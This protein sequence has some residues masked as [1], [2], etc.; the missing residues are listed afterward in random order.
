MKTVKTLR[1]G[2]LLLILTSFS[3]DKL[4]KTFT[5]LLDR[6][7]LTFQKPTG[8]EETQIIKNLEMNYEYAIK[9]PQRKFEVRYAI[10]P[11]DNLIRDY[12]EKE[13]KKNRGE[14]NIHPNKLYSSL[15]QVT[16]LN[17]SGGQLPELTVFDK[18]A[19]K[20]EFNADW[21]ATTFVEVGKEFGQEYKYCMIVAIH[22]DNC[23]DA[24]FF[25]LS[26]TKDGYDELMDP[27][28]HSLKFK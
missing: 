3:S 11:L 25:Y 28:F 20:Q 12:N 7:N 13:K 26:D 21:G 9:Y 15:L 10:R 16:T 18:H 14:I 22:K 8:L 2:L 1:A 5:D 4:P 27:A 19:V 24:Y 6:G 17:I 23:A